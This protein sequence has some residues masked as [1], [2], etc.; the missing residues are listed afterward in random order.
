[1]AER[2]ESGGNGEAPQLADLEGV[3]N[4]LFLSP[5]LGSA[6]SKMCHE[7]LTQTD[8]AS[9]NVLVV[10]FTRTP[11]EWVESWTDHTGVSPSRGAIVAVGEPT[12]SV[13]DP[14]WAVEAVENP[15]DLTGIG[16]KLS[17]MLSSLATAAEREDEPIAMCFDSIT[18]LLQYADLQRTFRFLHVVTGRVKSADGVAHYH[19]DPAAHD[20]QDL[21]TL[22]GL[23][24]AV[25]EVDDEGTVSVQR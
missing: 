1:M 17:E 4:V 10:S 11:T 8:P 9:T 16:I 22:K 18:S 15:S 19:V 3:S 7:L 2:L 24:D 12:T 23:F 21:A 13:D 5:S 20:A 14:A 6:A 25:V